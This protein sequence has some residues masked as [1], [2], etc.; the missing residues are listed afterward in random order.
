MIG[1]LVEFL[2][3]DSTNGNLA[4]YKLVALAGLWLAG[5]LAY[6]GAF[7]PAV[8]V[9][10]AVLSA[11]F[12]RNTYLRFL[13][14]HSSTVTGQFDTTITGNIRDLVSGVEPTE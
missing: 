13:E 7:W 1:K 4:L 10:I 12:G 14:R 6:K 8:T 3:L 11:S 9:F 2:D 5:V